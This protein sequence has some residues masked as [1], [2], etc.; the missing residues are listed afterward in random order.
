[1]TQQT[2]R[3]NFINLLGGGAVLA[4]LPLATGCSSMPPDIAIQAWNAP[5]PSLGIREFMLAHALLAPNPHNRQ[6]WIANLAIPNEITF[7]CDKDKLLPST[8]PFGRQILIGCGAFIELAVLAASERGFR[9]DVSLFPNGE[10]SA[11]TLPA[12]SVLARLTVVADSSIKP[13]PLFTQI[14]K[15][16]TNKGE[17]DSTKPVSPAA[18]QQL[19]A[20]AGSFKLLAGEVTDAKRLT[21][22][23]TIT[24]SAYEI[25]ITGKQ[26]WLESANLLRI[27]PTEIAQHRDGISVMGVMP[28][29]L[30]VTGVFDRFAVP[31]PGDS[32]YNNMMK[33][34]VP[35]ETGSGYYWLVS[36]GNDRKAQITSGRAYVRTHLQATALGI[37]MHPLSQALQEFPQMRAQYEAIHTELGF[38]PNDNTVQMLCR[39]G[40]GKAPAAPTPRRDLTKIV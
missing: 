25:E 12:G 28:R 30:S 31:V 40:Y 17:Y 38:K 32:N 37:D 18:W 35:F 9:V 2:T 15:R 33:R 22:I 20:V 4:A 39:V 6:P 19:T 8:D 7:I 10:P 1:M 34:W 24:R 29:L 26:T 5:D 27:G 11:D 16:H 36:K 21:T 23:S 3:R 14:R 13:D